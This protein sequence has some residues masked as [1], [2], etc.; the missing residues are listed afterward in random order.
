LRYITV[1]DIKTKGQSKTKTREKICPT[2]INYSD[3]PFDKEKWCSN[4]KYR[5]FPFDM[6]ELE[7]EGREFTLNGWWTGIEWYG[8]RKKTKKKVL[9]WKLNK[10]FN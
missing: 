5:P 10:E 6:C 7:I 1:G 3:V 4:P 8:L 9:N 2:Y